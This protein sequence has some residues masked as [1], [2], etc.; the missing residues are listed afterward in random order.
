M[1]IRTLSS[2]GVLLRV[3]WTTFRYVVVTLVSIK[4]KQLTREVADQ[5]LYDWS[6]DLLAILNVRFRI[7]NPLGVELAPGQPWVVM[8]NHRS[9][10]DIPLLFMAFPRGLRMVAKAELFKLPIWKVGLEAGEFIKVDRESRAGAA[11][12]IKEAKARMESGIA[13]M[14]FPEGTRARGDEMLPLKK[15][16]FMMAQQA[17]ASIVP[18]GI[19]GTGVV[20]PADRL[21][22]HWNQ[23]VELHIG[24]P[25][26][27]SR[28]TSRQRSE[29]MSE[30]ETQIKELSGESPNGQA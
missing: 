29:L 23:E 4:R 12:S 5:I 22:F 1:I 17:G 27:A 2:L 20:M 28:Y 16:G 19:R 24:R 9:Y 25:V 11:A 15:G 7:E 14:I 13:V 6:R 21:Q 10:Y 18:V 3:N 8:S 26:D 30:V